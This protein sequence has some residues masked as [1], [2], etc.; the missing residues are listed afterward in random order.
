[1]NYMVQITK[2]LKYKY[3]FPCQIIAEFPKSLTAMILFPSL[4]TCFLKSLKSR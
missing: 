4:L 3:I 2:E 1:M